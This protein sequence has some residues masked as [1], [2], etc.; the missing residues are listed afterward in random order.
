MKLLAAPVRARRGAARA[1]L[2]RRPQPRAPQ[3]PPG[4]VGSLRRRHDHL[5]V[6]DDPPAAR[7]LSMAH[8]QVRPGG[9]KL[10]AAGRRDHRRRQE[11][12]QAHVGDGQPRL[13]RRACR[14]SP[15]RVPPA[16]RAALAAAIKKSGV[17]AAGARP[18]GDLGRGLHPARQPVPATWASRAAK[19][20]RACCAA[21]SSAQGKPIGELESNVEQLGFFDTLAG[22]RA[23]RSCS[24]A[25][26]S[27]RRT[28][29]KDFGG[30]L[31]RLV[32]RRRQGDR[33]DLQPRPRRARP[34][35]GRR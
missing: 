29:N 16:K 28:M 4:A 10:A 34:S 21:T 12:D 22:K 1:R 27:S 2:P 7:E 17:P 5:S 33:P 32:A 14:R 19:A 6:R 20:S 15:Q 24:K 9:G 26:S 11:P 35:S 31:Q 18:D 25:R 3:S 13:L 23:A 30:M 8:R